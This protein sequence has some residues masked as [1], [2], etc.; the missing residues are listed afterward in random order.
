MGNHGQG[1][2]MDGLP[3][4]AWVKTGFNMTQQRA[5]PNTTPKEAGGKE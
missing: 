4:Q 1:C 2:V 3:A 5:R